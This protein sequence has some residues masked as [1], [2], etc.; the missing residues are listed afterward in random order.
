[1]DISKWMGTVS[2]ELDGLTREEWLALDKYLGKDKKVHRIF[3]IGT[4]KVADFI[5]DGVKVE[6]KGLKVN[7]FKGIRK[8]ALQ[9]AKESFPTLIEGG[10]NA[11]SLVVDCISNGQKLTIN[12]AA[13]IA[14]EVKR[15]YP[16]KIIE[17][18]TSV[19]DVVK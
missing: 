1:M 6:F 8:K 12:E 7:T 18:W 19:G 17:I 2:G 16:N 3:E 14:E 15:L 9:Y 4:E 5:V 13:T 11:D 10:K